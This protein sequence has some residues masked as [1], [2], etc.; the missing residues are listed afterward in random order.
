VPARPDAT[1]LLL[2]LATVTGWGLNWP[3]MKVLLSEIPPFTIRA[4]TGVIGVALLLPLAVLM[5]Q[6]LR[7]PRG[8]RLRL[9]ARLAAQRHGLDGARVLLAAL[10]RGGGGDDRLLHHARLDL[11]AGLGRAG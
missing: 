2:L 1:G 4:V 3:I 6:S 8:L 10:A 5:R 11:A 7:V 9:G